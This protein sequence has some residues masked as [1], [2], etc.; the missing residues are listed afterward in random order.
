MTV[1]SSDGVSLVFNDALFN[2][3]HLGGVQGFV[4]KYIT[5]SSGDLH[6]SR[7]ARLFIVKDRAAFRAHIERLAETPELRR[8]LVSHH[9]TR[10]ENVA[11]ALRAAVSRL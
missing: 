4:L 1:R 6:V 9:L 8:V 10:S 7:I 3:P 11:S 5:Q 2:M